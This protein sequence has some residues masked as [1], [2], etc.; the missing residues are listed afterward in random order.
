MAKVKKAS[1]N[2][3]MIHNQLTIVSVFG[4][5]DGSSAIPAILKSMEELPGSRG[6]L[7]SI[8]KPQNLP[9][10]IKWKHIHNLNYKQYTLFM[11]HCLY[12]FIE[13][14]YCLT[15]QEDGWVLNGNN[16]TEKYYEYDYI[17][18]ITHCAI[19]MDD[20]LTSLNHLFL[21]FHW[22]GKADS[23]T[24]VIQNGGFSLRSKRF[25]EACNVHGITHTTDLGLKLNIDGKEELWTPIWNEDV[26]L[27]GMLR[28]KL[29]RHGYK[30]APTEVAMEFGV[31]YLHTELHK[32][33]DFNTIVGH[34][35]KSRVLMADNTIKLP[36]NAGIL[37]MMEKRFVEWLRDTKKYKFILDSE[38][39]SKFGMNSGS[40]G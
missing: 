4:H 2:N 28:P 38:W 34:H 14:D 39:Q 10:E 25:L 17:G 23:T 32:T 8:Q 21:R 16:L 35:A 5:N 33:M 37:G 7:L 3:T 22:C 30:Y 15:V 24:F 36:S 6:L 1:T 12:A 20:T 19:K 13:T 26:Q 11:M 40:K 31:E 29:M 27:S 18:P 9:A